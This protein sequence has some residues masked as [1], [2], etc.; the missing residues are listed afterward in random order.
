MN[1]P[2]STKKCIWGKG[3]TREEVTRGSFLSIFI[4]SSFQAPAAVMMLMLRLRIPNTRK[5]L[6]SI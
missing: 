3:I 5:I 6:T 4:Y 2:T 1:V